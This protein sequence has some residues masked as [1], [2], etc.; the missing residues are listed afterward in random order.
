VLHVIPR[1][2]FCDAAAA[3]FGQGNTSA[4]GGALGSLVERLIE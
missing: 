3:Q 2:S 1:H 4:L